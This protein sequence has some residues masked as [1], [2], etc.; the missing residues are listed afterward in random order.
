MLVG[1][2]RDLS[3]LQPVL[4]LLAAGVGAVQTTDGQPVT[5]GLVQADKLRPARRRVV[6][7]SGGYWLPLTLD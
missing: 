6:E 5:H 1:R 4:A 3:G 2:S 7:W